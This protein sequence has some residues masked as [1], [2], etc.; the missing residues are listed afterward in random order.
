MKSVA[1]VLYRRLRASSALAPAFSPSELFASGEQGVWYDPS[2]LTTLF[3]DAAGTT[4]VTGLE[5]PVGLM[6]DKSKGLVLGSEAVVTGTAPW[7][8]G[9]LSVDGTISAS[10]NAVTITQGAGDGAGFRWVQPVTCVIGRYYRL[11]IGSFSRSGGT[12]AQIGMAAN[13]SGTGL[14]GGGN[15]FTDTSG[16]TVIYVAATAATMY[17]TISIAGGSTGN[18]ATFTDISVRELPGNHAAQSTAASRPVLSARYNLLTYSQAFSNAVWGARAYV[19][20]N[21]ATAPD[22][23]QTAARVYN[24]GATDNVAQTVT[25]VAGTAY[26]FTFR[27]KN[28]GGTTASYRVYNLTGSADIVAVTSYFSQLSSTDW[29]TITVTFTA[30]VG[31]TQ[32]VVYLSAS[33]GPTSNI[34]VWGADLRVANDGVGLPAYQRV[35]TSTDYD[36][37][38]FPYYL[39]YDGTDDSMSTGNIDFTA[40][41]KMSVFA[42]VRKLSDATAFSIVA[43]FGVRSAAGSWGLYA[44]GNTGTFSYISQG[45][46]I[47]AVET[48]ATLTAP[49]TRTL[50]CTSNIGADAVSLSL[51]GGTAITSSADQGAG[52]YGNYALYLGARNGGASLWASIRDYGLVVLGRTPTAAEITSMEAWMDGKTK[53]I[54]ASSAVTWDATADTYTQNLYNGLGV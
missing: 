45:S 52:N 41:D 7:A 49:V 40:T 50:T 18:S 29:A 13:S 54:I 42:G 38:G 23:T 24:T 11:T 4:P 17:V 36:T 33:N 37:T 14:I 6:L 30:P 43:E 32:A 39:R 5:Q 21:F 16:V 48:A 10:G 22:G 53:A 31:C 35:T 8:R 1:Q 51:N 26:T 19:T 9:F 27:A 25:V 20:D 34:L 47:V 28:N 46:S 3:Q 15:S 2:D 44:P 12:A